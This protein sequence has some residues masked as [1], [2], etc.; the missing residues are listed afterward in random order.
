VELGAELGPKIRVNAVAPAVVKTQFATA[1]YEGREE[2]VA[3]AY[4]MKRLGVPS[5]I[6]G[7]VAFLLSDDAGWL[8][9][10]TVVLDGG[11]TLGGGL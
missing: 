8:T 4:P 6:A 1:L 11:V 9:G 5:D 7:A 10:Q 3:S 2:E